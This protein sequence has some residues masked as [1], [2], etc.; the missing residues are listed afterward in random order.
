MDTTILQERINELYSGIIEIN[1]QHISL[2]GFYNSERLLSHL[3]D[4]KLN[5]SSM[6]LY[7]IQPIKYD[8]IKTNALFILRENGIEIKKYQFKNVL[9][10]QFSFKNKKGKVL[11]TI[12]K[13]IHGEEYSLLTEKKNSIFINIESL[14]TFIRNTYKEGNT[15]LIGREL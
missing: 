7:D 1:D 5:Y 12:R 8:S 10:Q 2:I 9:K 14:T 13:N 15:F 6:G 4:G 3:S 11:V